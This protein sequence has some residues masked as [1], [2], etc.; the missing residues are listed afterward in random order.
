MAAKKKTAAAAEESVSLT[1]EGG[2]RPRLQKLLVRNFRSIGPTPVE[3]E[4]DDIVVLVGPNNAG[5]SSILRAYETVMM[6]GS[7]EGR[8]IIAD[9][10]DGVVEQ[11]RLP[12]IELHTIISTDAPGKRWI[13]D[14]GNGEMLIREQW[15][16]DSPNKDPIRRGYD[17][18]KGDWDDEVPWGA[19]NVANSR[20]PQPHRIDAFQHPDEQ[21]KAIADLVLSILKERIA[22]V[23]SDPNAEKSDYELVIDRIRE[24]QAKV[25]AETED[26]V[27]KIE[28]EISTYLKRVFPLHRVRVDAKAETDVEKTYVPFRSNPDVLMGAEG[29]YF[30][31]IAHQGSGARRT[32]LWATL[33]YLKERADGTDA[34]PHVLLLDEPEICLHPSAIREARAVL[35]SLPSSASWQIMITSHSPLFIDLSQDNTTVIRVYRDDSSAV[36]STT[37]FRPSRAQLSDDDKRNMKL[38][39]LCDPYLHE[40]FFGGRQIVVEGDTEF[41]AFGFIR[42]IY[43]D[44]YRDVQIIRARGKGVIPSVARVLL[45]FSKNFSILHDTDTPKTAKGKNNPAWGMNKSIANVLSFDNAADAVH[46]VACKTCFEVALFGEEAKDEKP[47]S[48]LERIRTDEAARS[49]V[50]A[51]LDGLLDESKELPADCL[52]WKTVADLE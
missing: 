20:R 5:K 11:T 4:L 49:R 1:V 36:K 24:L 3:I 28:A 38:L 51:L 27:Q 43:P 29:G 31:T 40:F 35:Y 8:L 25:A 39:N 26:E 6:H 52:R 45:Q 12:Q 42:E 18:E 17:V 16:W 37:L 50:K 23:K 21:A 46:L 22:Q 10:P 47:Y 7:K 9:F 30:S 33:K 15:V 19:P 34:R 44:E 48:A 32:L 14:L 41:T 2:A 13:K